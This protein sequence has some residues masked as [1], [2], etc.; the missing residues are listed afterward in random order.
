M[1]VFFSFS[2]IFLLC[3]HGEEKTVKSKKEKKNIVI[4]KKYNPKYKLGI[5]D[6]KIKPVLK[7]N[8]HGSVVTDDGKYGAE[9]RRYTRIAKYVFVNLNKV[10]RHRK[11]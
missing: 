10:L 1:P 3:S 8:S 6:I 9:V 2:L 5:R 11:I 4:S 7:F